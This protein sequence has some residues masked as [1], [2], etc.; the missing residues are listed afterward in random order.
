MLEKLNHKHA[1]DFYSWSLTWTVTLSTI[2]QL[3]IIHEGLMLLL[4]LFLYIQ[5]KKSLT[6]KCSTQNG[7]KSMRI[8][9][10]VNTGKKTWVVC[11][12]DIGSSEL[13]NNAKK[14]S[15]YCNITKKSPNA[16]L[17][18]FRAETWCLTQ[19]TTLNV[20]FRANNNPEFANK[21]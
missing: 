5:G 20:K 8:L 6:I 17:L 10:W 18:Q 12:G 2:T 1:L 11:E 15:K 4:C 19:T 9:T 16:A 14:F 21:W 13:W 3:K 7:W